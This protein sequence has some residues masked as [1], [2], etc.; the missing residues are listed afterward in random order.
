MSC[1]I[2]PNRVSIHTCNFPRP[3]WMQTETPKPRRIVSKGLPHTDTLATL[4]SSYKHRWPAVGLRL[5]NH[6]DREEEKI[7][8]LFRGWLVS[9]VRIMNRPRYGGLFFLIQAISHKNAGGPVLSTS[10]EMTGPNRMRRTP[11]GAQ[12]S[13]GS[14]RRTPHRLHPSLGKPWSGRHTSNRR[15]IGRPAGI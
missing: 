10:N 8:E 7:L 2:F 4:T 9:G 5:H 14:P 3:L 13:L 12:A 15:N 1:L 6:Q 11:W